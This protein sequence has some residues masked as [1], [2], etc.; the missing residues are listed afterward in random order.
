[1]KR[2]TLADS[3][4]IAIL[5][6][7]LIWP[8]FRLKYMD[9]W[10]SIE[11]TFISDARMLGENLPH[12]GWQPLWYSGTRYDY[13]YPPALRYGTALLAKAGH[14]T[15]ARAYHLYTAFLYVFGILAVYWMVLTGTASR[16]AALLAAAGTALLSPSFALLNV[17]RNDSRHWV[18]QRLHVLA[19]YGEGPHISALCVLPAALAASFLALRKWRPGMFAAAAVL[20]ALVVSNNFYG[21]TSLAIFFPVL[22]WAVWT[23]DRDWRIIPRAVGIAALAWGL[24]AVWLTPSYI[25]IT[26]MNLKWVAQPASTGFRIATFIVMALYCVITFRRRSSPAWTVFVTGVALF[27][28]LDILGYYYLGLT[29][30]GDPPRLLPELDLALILVVVEV[31]RRW[32]IAT[33]L[34]TAA[35]LLL[36][37]PY[38]R[39]AWTPFPKS[40]PLESRYP[41]QMSKWVHDN[42]P[43]QRVMPTGELR[44]WFDA[45]FDNAQPDGGSMQGLLN[46]GFMAARWEILTGDKPAPAIAW[47]QALGTDAVVIAGEK[48]SETY[49]DYKYPGKFEGALPVLYRDQEG[50]VV[51]RIP[52]VYP[53]I[54]RVVSKD[55]GL[56][57]GLEKYLAIVESPDQP[58]TSVEWK[59]FD[60]V[61]IQAKTAPGRSVLLQETYDPDWHAFEGDKELSVR[62]EPVMGFMLIDMPAGDHAIRM[63]FETPLE[64]RVGQIL[65][66]LSLIIAASMSI[67]AARRT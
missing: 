13:I 26:L 50:T 35:A 36:S 11:S 34:V 37:V 33:L 38:L 5:A 43:G 41:Y 63:R 66:I 47:L 65:T 10:E 4:L 19:R 7:I 53:N 42:L 15:T 61:D 29:L 49:H 46:Q 8:L 40:G 25:K 58:P 20:C 62:L 60:E 56:A 9:N 48:S 22:V 14:L 18:P 1:M 52:R 24:C 32:R 64:N 28:S 2:T 6:T 23:Q 57:A 44:F 39:H 45:W 21:A 54:G 67:N 12:P 31:A 51:Y 3:L 27:L 16:M 59:G 17:I 55:A 30:V